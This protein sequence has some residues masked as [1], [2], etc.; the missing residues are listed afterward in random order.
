MTLTEKGERVWGRVCIVETRE[1]FGVV[2]CSRSLGA[3][4]GWGL[5][6]LRLVEIVH[7]GLAL[8][9][10]MERL[11]WHWCFESGGAKK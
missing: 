3:G 7:G 1:T 5:S 4:R 8:G 11:R 10:W 6:L 9:R 2:V